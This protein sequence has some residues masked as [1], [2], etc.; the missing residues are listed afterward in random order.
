VI[1]WDLIVFS[2]D[3]VSLNVDVLE[4]GGNLLALLSD[5]KFVVGYL[6]FGYRETYADI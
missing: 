1:G 4:K 2:A 3:S 6:F 5:H